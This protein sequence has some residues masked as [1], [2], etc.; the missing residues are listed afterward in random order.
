MPNRRHAQLQLSTVTAAVRWQDDRV[1]PEVA[2]NTSPPLAP[3]S[4]RRDIAEALSFCPR[5]LSGLPAPVTLVCGRDGSAWPTGAIVITTSAIA[6]AALTSMPMPWPTFTGT[7]LAAMALAVEHDRGTPAALAEWC[8]SKL[9]IGS[10]W[11]LTAVHA[12]GPV[13]GRF[14]PRGWSIGRVFRAL[15]LELRDV[16]VGDEMPLVAAGEVARDVP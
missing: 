5:L 9:S 12:L 4:V 3:A 15:G 6:Y 1:S 13:A 2:L 10:A 11:R 8:D 14:D 7:E 16:V